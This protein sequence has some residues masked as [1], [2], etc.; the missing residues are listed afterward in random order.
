MTTFNKDDLRESVVQTHDPKAMII[1]TV[2]TVTY[3]ADTAISTEPRH[4]PYNLLQNYT[5]TGTA[6]ELEKVIEEQRPFLG[7]VSLSGQATVWYAKPNTGK[8]LL[9]MHL[10][11]EAVTKGGI[12]PGQIYYIAADDSAHGLVEKLHIMEEYGINVL[13]PGHAGFETKTLAQVL[14]AMIHHDAAAGIYVVADTLKKFMSLMDK[15]EGRAFGELIRQFTMKGGTFLAL[16]HTNKQRSSDG[17]LVY[18]GTS[19]IMEDFDCAYVIDELAD[20]GDTQ[21]RVVEFECTKRRGNVAQTAA[22]SFTLDRE[23]TYA[24][25]LSSVD[26]VDTAAVDAFHKQAAIRT[27]A[28][29]IE[30]IETAIAEGINTKMELARTVGTRQGLGRQSVVKLIERYTGQDPAVHRWDFSV[31]ERGKKVYVM[32]SAAEGS[33][34]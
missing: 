6:G 3:V 5:L 12:D 33:A 15:T 7:K 4:H 34:G 29:I 18:A 17:K 30:A 32:L 21:Q 10:M 24:G 2:A 14:K 31:G 8:T 27:D 26:E 22:Y 25:M 11:I 13:S 23:A 9:A 16:A 1:P 28:T 20:V 19:D